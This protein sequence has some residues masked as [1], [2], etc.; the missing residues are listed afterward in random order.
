MLN[1]VTGKKERIGK[2]YQMHA[3]KRERSRRS[4]PGRSWRLRGP[5]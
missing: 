1:S 2:V 5:C 4:A 3:N